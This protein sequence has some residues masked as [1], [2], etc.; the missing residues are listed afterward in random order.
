MKGAFSLNNLLV[1]TVR[2]P[3]K[4]NSKTLSASASAMTLKTFFLH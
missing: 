1:G 4:L 2:P 3:E